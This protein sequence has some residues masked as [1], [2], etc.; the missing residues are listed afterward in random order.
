M[1]RCPVARTTSMHT[2][3]HRRQHTLGLCLCLPLRLCLCLC[4]CVCVCVGTLVAPVL[5]CGC[6]SVCCCV[7]VSV[8]RVCLCVSACVSVSVCV[9]VFLCLGVFVVL[10]RSIGGCFADSCRCRG[11]RRAAG[12][13]ESCST[14]EEDRAGSQ[15]GELR[16]TGCKGGGGALA[17]VAKLFDDRR[18]LLPMNWNCDALYFQSGVQQS[19]NFQFRIRNIVCCNPSQ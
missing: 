15:E 2:C 17:C 10:I 1:S 5:V 8:C 3:M 7:S 13:G 12:G 9:C 4:A 16:G 19:A 11:S 18:R 6:V 14:E